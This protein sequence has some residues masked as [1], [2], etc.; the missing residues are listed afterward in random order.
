MTLRYVL[1]TDICEGTDTPCYGVQAVMCDRVVAEARGISASFDEVS[2]LIELCN[3]L[4]LSV[5]H[6]YDVID[7]FI[8]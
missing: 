5:I 2:R 7:D 8:G 1:V 6:F 3:G 4:G